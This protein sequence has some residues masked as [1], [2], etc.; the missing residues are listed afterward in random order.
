MSKVL[1]SISS[2]L[3]EPNPDDPLMPEIAH[4]LKTNR[5]VHDK[6][7]LLF[8]LPFALLHIHISQ[9]LCLV[10]AATLPSTSPVLFS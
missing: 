9:L 3:N 2:L 10:L 1:L 8:F 6:V 7:I 5:P 4:L